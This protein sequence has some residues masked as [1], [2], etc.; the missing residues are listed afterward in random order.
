MQPLRC[1]RVQCLPAGAAPAHEPDAELLLLLAR[2]SLPLGGAAVLH[3]ELG[4]GIELSAT[5]AVIVVPPFERRARASTRRGRRDGLRSRRRWPVRSIPL[6][7]AAVQLDELGLGVELLAPTA[8]IVV[9]LLL[10]GAR[11]SMALATCR[12]ARSRLGPQALGT[13][14]AAAVAADGDAATESRLF[15]HCDLP[16][17]LPLFLHDLL[18]RSH[19]QPNCLTP[20][21]RH[22]LVQAAVQ[23]AIPELLHPGGPV[24]H[25]GG[26]SCTAGAQTV[27]V[28]LGE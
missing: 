24:V 22:D 13:G 27:P 18:K 6:G 19:L 11:S 1:L 23:L 28:P 8:V 15:L 3:E 25:G 20:R 5:T 17:L 9:P 26:L 2:R 10:G 4:L 14:A 21:T 7:A 12:A 16:C